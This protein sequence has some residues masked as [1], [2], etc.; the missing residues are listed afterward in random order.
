MMKDRGMAL[1]DV[2][3][4]HD[5]FF[6]DRMIALDLCRRLR[7]AS[8]RL[9]LGWGCSAGLEALGNIQPWIS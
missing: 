8:E 7:A 1:K 3:F 9:G 4:V 6:G 2:N 5:N